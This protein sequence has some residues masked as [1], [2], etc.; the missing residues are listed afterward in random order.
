MSGFF[1]FR[2]KIINGLKFDAIGYKILLKL[3]VKTKGVRVE[4]IPY[5]FTDRKFSSSKLDSSTIIDYYKSVWKLY[6]YGR[7]VR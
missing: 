2:Q 5:I 7:K 6:K 3:L 4:E 1:V